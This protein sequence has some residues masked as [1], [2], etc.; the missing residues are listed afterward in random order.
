VQRKYLR[1]GDIARLTGASLRTVRRW[2]SAGGIPSMK[3]GGA[4]LVADAELER[5]L[6]PLST[7]VEE[8]TDDDAK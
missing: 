3:L 7:T 4:R 5:L 6:S 1:A 2:I 8:D